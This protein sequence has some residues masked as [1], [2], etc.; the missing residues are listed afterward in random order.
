MTN[1]RTWLT[2][3]FLIML[4]GAP[5][6]WTVPS[7]SGALP[8]VSTPEIRSVS[9]ASPGR[10]SKLQ[11]LTVSGTD[12]LEGLTLIMTNPGGQTHRFA[13]GDILNRRTTTF[14][15]DTLLD[16]AGEYSLV[17]TNTDGGTSR[18]F[19]LALQDSA[20]AP[21]TKPTIESVTPA[22]VTKSNT[23]QS[24]TVRGTRFEAGLVVLLT[25]PTGNVTTISG[26][27]L[28]DITATSFRMTATL[29]ISGEYSVE[30]KLPSG[31]VSN[32]SVIVAE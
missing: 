4:M 18:P 27:Q 24:F 10:S 25:D 32:T 21:A 5:S 8:A 3:A 13:G 7:T 19:V 30:V 23:P 1:P 28:G 9:P 31:A 14:E 6:A 22:K 26:N 16:T 29:E 15:V 2:T 20:P 11:R 17:V 12:F